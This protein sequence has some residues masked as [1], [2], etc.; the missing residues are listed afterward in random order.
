MK[1]DPYRYVLLNYATPNLI[2][3]ITMCAVLMTGNTVPV[4]LSLDLVNVFFMF[5]ACYFLYWFLTLYF[6]DRGL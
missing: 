2:A 3:F 6:E 4:S 1:S 5:W